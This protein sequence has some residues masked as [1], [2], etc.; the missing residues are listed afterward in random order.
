MKKFIFTFALGFFL[1][2]G[3]FAITPPLYAQS[4]SANM[5]IPE[6]IELLIALDMIPAEKINDVREIAKSFSKNPNKSTTPT[7][8]AWTDKDTVVV[9]ETFVVSWKSSNDVR[10]LTGKLGDKDNANGSQAI[11]SGV[12]GVYIYPIKVYDEKGNMGACEAR[13]TVKEESSMVPSAPTSPPVPPSNTKS[14]NT[15][16]VEVQGEGHVIA[17]GNPRR[18]SCGILSNDCQETYATGTVVTLTVTKGR[19]PVWKG[20]E[21]VSKKG[22]NCTLRVNQ[23]NTSVV[24]NFENIAAL[25]PPT[26]TL[27]KD[28]ESYVLG[29]KVVLSWKSI[30]AQYVQFEEDTSGKDY[31]TLPKETLGEHGTYSITADVLGNGPV[32][33]VAYN[34]MGS[35]VC[36]VVIPV[37]E[38]IVNSSVNA[39]VLQS[40]ENNS[41]VLKDTK[42]EKE[43]LSFVIDSSGYQDK[44][45]LIG[46]EGMTFSIGLPFVKAGYWR[47][48]IDSIIL[49]SKEGNHGSSMDVFKA[50][51]HDNHELMLGGQLHDEITLVFN[52][53][54]FT[55]F[56]SMP[57]GTRRTF[58]VIAVF[59]PGAVVGPFGYAKR[60]NS[61]TGYVQASIVHIDGPVIINGTNQGPLF[62]V[63]SMY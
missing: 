34:S 27:T 15:L 21:S 58:K 42:V 51:D 26:C 60:Y 37:E 43:L 8:T 39:Y 12:P 36:S 29:E 52:E 55:N 31:I 14:K 4:Q 13:V 11:S 57:A 22:Y 25:K 45:V 61:S 16:F 6:F 62:S 48:M 47:D 24:A 50:T 5:S 20:C 46:I 49:V 19:R 40:I 10:F 2:G 9:D 28:K 33:L 18:I 1:F 41:I 63:Q 7:C 3:F 54:K 17:Q 30:G 59:K 56:F 35:S 53:P 32:K 23:P 44:D 38:R